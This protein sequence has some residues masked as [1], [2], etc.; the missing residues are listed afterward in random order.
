MLLNYFKILFSFIKN[1]YRLVIIVYALVATLFVFLLMNKNGKLSDENERYYVNQISLTE[2]IE[3]YKTESGKNA[4]KI[5]ELTL[6]NGKLLA[7]R[8]AYIVKNNELE[9]ILNITKQEKKD[10]V[11]F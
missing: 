10:I 4:V 5:T 11:C 9:E 1:N 7:E 2:D 3:T 6:E 8:S